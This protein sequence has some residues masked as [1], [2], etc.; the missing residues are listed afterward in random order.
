MVLAGLVFYDFLSGCS[1]VWCCWCGAVPVVDLRRQGL[2]SM[3]SMHA[4]QSVPLETCK[5]GYVH[6][7]IQLVGGRPCAHPQVVCKLLKLQATQNCRHHPNSFGAIALALYSLGSS[8]SKQVVVAND[9][10]EHSLGLLPLTA[11]GWPY[12]M[13]VIL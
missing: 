1:V 3:A 11:P 13:M 12:G 10:Q 8:K 7:F 4:V 9:R 6:E 5:D 2:R